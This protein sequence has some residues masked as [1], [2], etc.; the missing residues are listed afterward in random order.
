MAAG[1]PAAVSQNGGPSESLQ[2]EHGSYGILVDPHD[3]NDIADGLTRLTSDETAWQAMQQAGMQ[4]IA[5]Q[6][7]WTRTAQGYLRQLRDIVENQTAATPSYPIPAYFQ[8]ADH[9]D[10]DP[11]WLAERYFS[12]M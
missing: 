4:R 1:L 2:D 7:T 5:D 12:E 6:Y 9:D 3:P 8:N 11:L 10:I